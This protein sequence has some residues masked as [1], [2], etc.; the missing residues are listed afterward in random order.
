VRAVVCVVVGCVNC[1]T[2]GRNFS[3]PTLEL[4]SWE[5]RRMKL[6]SQPS[7]SAALWVRVRLPHILPSLPMRKSGFFGVERCERQQSLVYVYV[8]EYYCWDY[9]APCWLFGA[10]WKDGGMC[11]W[12][13]GAIA[14]WP[15]KGQPTTSMLKSF[16]NVIIRW[17]NVCVL[18]LYYLQGSGGSAH[19]EWYLLLLLLVGRLK[20][21]G[22]CSWD[23]GAIAAWPW[24]GQPTMS[25]LK[26][27]MMLSVINTMRYISTISRVHEMATIWDDSS[28]FRPF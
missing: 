26:C 21:G 27:F 7:T 10:F 28:W 13:M 2:N 9:A 14:A 6:A 23:M 3:L 20:D 18:Y 4:S 17:R 15:W 1:H 5:S 22:M 8:P 12:D 19:M 16:C 24:K 11:S 25:M